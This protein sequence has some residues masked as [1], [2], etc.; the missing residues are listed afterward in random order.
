[1]RVEA[2]ADLSEASLATRVALMFGGILVGPSVE[3]AFV[4]LVRSRLT[5]AE[6]PFPA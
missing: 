1:M 2:V 6:V 3:L 5:A 4:G